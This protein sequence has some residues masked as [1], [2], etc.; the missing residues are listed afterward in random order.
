MLIL[1]QTLYQL[2]T[3]RHIYLL[4]V[5]VEEVYLMVVVAELVDSLQEHLQLLKD[6]EPFIQQL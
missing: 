1:Q 3:L 2:I 5:A 6:Q 4:Q